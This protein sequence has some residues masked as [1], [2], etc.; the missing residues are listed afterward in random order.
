MNSEQ[1]LP[2]NNTLD[3]DG[4]DE[5]DDTPLEDHD[6]DEHYESP[7]DDDIEDAHFNDDNDDDI[8]PEPYEPE[9][10]PFGTAPPTFP[11]RPAPA[12]ASRAAQTL[13]TTLVSA[14]HHLSTDPDPRRTL[15]DMEQ[16]N[17]LRRE[18]G[19][20]STIF[21]KLA[22][23]S[24]RGRRI[25][26]TLH[27]KMCR[28]ID[29]LCTSALSLIEHP[30][31]NSHP[32]A[33]AV[34]RHAPE[35][36][37]H[38]R[39]LHRAMKDFPTDATTTQWR[40]L[41]GEY[42]KDLDQLRTVVDNPD[43]RASMLALHRRAQRNVLF[44][45]AFD[46]TRGSY[47][48]S[49]DR[50]RD[51]MTSSIRS[52]SDNE[53]AFV[54]LGLAVQIAKPAVRF[55]WGMS[56]T[57]LYSTLHPTTQGAKALT[58]SIAKT[59]RRRRAASRI[60]TDTAKDPNRHLPETTKDPE[61]DHA[62]ADRIKHTANTFTQACILIPSSLRARL[63]HNINGLHWHTL[64]NTNPLQTLRRRR[65]RKTGDFSPTLEHGLRNNTLPNAFKPFIAHVLREI[66]EL[67]DH[68]IKN[69]PVRE[70][71]ETAT[72]GL[73]IAIN[74]EHAHTDLLI[75][76][77]VIDQLIR[78]PK[79]KQDVYEGNSDTVRNHE[80][81]RHMIP[82]QSL[83]AQEN[84]RMGSAIEIADRLD[85]AWRQLPIEVARDIATLDV[86]PHPNKHIHSSAKD[87]QEETRGPNSK[88]P[89]TPGNYYVPDLT[90]GPEVRWMAS[91]T[92][93][94]RQ[95]VE[96]IAAGYGITIT[97]KTRFGD[98]RKLRDPEQESGM[99]A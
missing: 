68:E 1:P 94:V 36:P 3:D 4:L 30:H 75:C 16:R 67:K 39:K 97:A 42:G 70:Q 56:L 32:F 12:L 15:K 25:P 41:Y 57:L 2:D 76:G 9:D 52:N 62:D 10:K 44:R 5:Y 80:F 63:N 96:N 73:E 53:A 59:V 17:Q 43:V 81:V 34:H 29:S 54:L 98:R 28:N 84:T 69:M 45:A 83:S 21:V 48:Q 95:R 50:I 26:L 79:Y 92:S 78:H 86:E 37:D 49:T 88:R 27:N 18:L 65:Q 6:L 77:T 60:G 14:K 72:R 64:Q 40:A 19:G 89:A 82:F 66:C 61:S 31:G 74:T 8:G 51:T 24:M 87:L 90:S 7:I 47:R 33:A 46:N 85:T 55:A 20:A 91:A 22:N 11:P 93:I 23:E 35:L 71:V 58:R 13:R 99:G 38:L